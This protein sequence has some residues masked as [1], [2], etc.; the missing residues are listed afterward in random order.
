M[1][2]I[3]DNTTSGT[4][5]SS[6]ALPVPRE[7]SGRWWAVQFT[8]LVLCKSR[9]GAAKPGGDDADGE[10]SSSAGPSKVANAGR[11]DT[12]G[13]GVGGVPGEGTTVRDCLMSTLN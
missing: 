7:L 3:G 1:V 8:V 12:R 5:E 6:T 9:G 11:G 2:D 4:G 10:R 13:G